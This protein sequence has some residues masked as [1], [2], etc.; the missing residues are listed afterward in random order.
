MRVVKGNLVKNGLMKYKRLVQF[1][2]RIIVVSILMDVMII[3]AM[4][5]PNGFV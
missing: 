3:G 2:Q 4:D 1:N 5:I